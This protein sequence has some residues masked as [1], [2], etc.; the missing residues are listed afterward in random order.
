MPE[1]WVRA[2][3]PPYEFL[4]HRVTVVGALRLPTLRVLSTSV[5][6][7]WWVRYAYPPYEFLPH[8][9]TVVGARCLPTLRVP[10]RPHK[11]T[12]CGWAHRVSQNAV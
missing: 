5:M 8:W 2:A 11:K 10:A 4:P 3:Y 6:P 12:R 7:E 9:V 1:W